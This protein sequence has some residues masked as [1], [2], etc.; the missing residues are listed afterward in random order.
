MANTE[1]TRRPRRPNRV[2]RVVWPDGSESQGRTWDELLWR[3]VDDQWDADELDDFTLREE[4]AFRA[5]QWSGTRIDW[6]DVNA[7]EFFRELERARMLQILEDPDLEG[8]T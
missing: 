7:R 2:A 1:R 6:A 3:L 8:T 5:K 4:M